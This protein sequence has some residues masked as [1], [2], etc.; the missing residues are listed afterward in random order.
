MTKVVTGA[1]E[2]FKGIEQVKFEGLQSD[3]PMAFR[4]YDANKVVA[5]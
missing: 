4:W 2:F 1:K 3:N 5:G